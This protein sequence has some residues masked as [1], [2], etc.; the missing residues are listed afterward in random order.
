MTIARDLETYG[1][2]TDATLP[3]DEA[4]AYARRVT[5]EHGENFSVVSR[6]LPRELREDFCGVYA[7]C[8]WADDLGD[9][10]H[11]ESDPIRGAELL[12]WWRDELDRCYAGEPRHPVY[13]AL[14]PVIGKHELP[15][16]PF[17]D[18]IDAFT[19]DQAVRRYGTWASLLDYCTRSADPVGRLVLTMFGVRD[20]ESF[21]LSDATCTALQLTNF[22]QDV[23]RDILERERVYL[24]A[25]VAAAHGLDVET[26]VRMTK[27]DEAARC[28]AC[29]P[30]QAVAGRE[31]LPAYRA[32]VRELVG[33]TWP[34]FAEGRGLWPR[35]GPR[36]RG[37]LELFTRG[38]EAVL[39]RIE[40][41]GCDTWTR[42]PRLGK[43]TKLALVARVMAG[44]VTGR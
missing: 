12:R 40:R 26:L 37:Q 10:F 28:D 36:F 41:R 16:R 21:R 13:V 8:R 30:G 39:R 3:L 17:D 42:R 27:L 31:L 32:T 7:V 18:L 44:R 23:R 33:R 9:A 6:L 2:D 22:W 1:P 35:V 14:E 5:R 20:D 43:W 34:M 19:Q 24:P 4:R 11:D 15:R 38:G 25:E 29:R